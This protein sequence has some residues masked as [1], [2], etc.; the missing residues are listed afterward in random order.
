MSED[1]V[2]VSIKLDKETI[3]TL[4]RMT[5]SQLIEKIL[6]VALE[7]KIA[8]NNAKD[9]QTKLDKSEAYVEQARAMIEAVMNRWYEYDV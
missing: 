1:Y 4:N 8:T 3:N 5:K 9:M 7:A 2:D 6:A